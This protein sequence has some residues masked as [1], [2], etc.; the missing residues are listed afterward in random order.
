MPFSSDANSNLQQPRSLIYFG[1]S[2]MGSGSSNRLA[3]L[4]SASIGT[5]AA[6][7]FLAPSVVT[8]LGEG[9]LYWALVTNGGS[10]TND[11]ILN[12]S[13]GNIVA[14]KAGSVNVT[15]AGIITLGNITGLGATTTYQILYMQLNAT[16]NLTGQTSASGAT[17]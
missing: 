8:D 12:G 14:G 10:A 16:G 4:S 17:L 2:G 9:I 3:V 1:A 7:S 15:A 5:S 11:Q 6:S 13:G